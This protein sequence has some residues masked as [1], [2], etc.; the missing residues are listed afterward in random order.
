M[1]RL[2]YI[3]VNNDFKIYSV[4]ICFLSLTASEKGHKDT[5][6]L[7]LSKGASVNK[8]NSDGMTPLDFGT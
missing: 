3:R 8:K 1:E 7:L 6:K 4:A 2:L 5:V